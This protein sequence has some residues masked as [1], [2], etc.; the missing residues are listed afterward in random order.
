[1]ETL[2]LDASHLDLSAVS[3][4]IRNE[5]N[6]AQ[7][8]NLQVRVIPDSEHETHL[9]QYRKR[10][11]L[12]MPP[13]DLDIPR[14]YYGAFTPDGTYLCSMALYPLDDRLVVQGVSIDEK[15]P[16]YAFSYLVYCGLDLSL[17][18]GKVGLDLAGEGTWKHKWNPH[19]AQNSLKAGRSLTGGLFSKI[20]AKFYWLFKK[21]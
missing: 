7:R 17:K 12:L 20:L 13:F 18:S 8:E 6:R 11:G 2:V 19:P 5:V 9:R 15:S 1:M 16:Y 10:K 3:K 4:N 14:T 21:S